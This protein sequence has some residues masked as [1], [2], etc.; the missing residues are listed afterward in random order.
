MSEGEPDSNEQ[1]DAE[2]TASVSDAA[3]AVAL[4]HQIGESK[5][6]NRT[7]DKG[8]RSEIHEL[9]LPSHA[10]WVHWNFSEPLTRLEFIVDIQNEPSS[11]V[12]S[13]LSLYE[14]TID[15]TLF[16]W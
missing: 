4:D 3:S 6:A 16:T 7:D 9:K 11:K 8:E 14:A 1:L 10:I 13:Y 15:G 5:V 12:G 2:T